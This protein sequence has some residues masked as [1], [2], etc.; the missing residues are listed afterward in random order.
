MNT[1]LSR[2][3]LVFIIFISSSF[4]QQDCP[5]KINLQPMYGKEKKCPGQIEAD[6]I[7][8][9]AMDQEFHG[10]R[11]EASRERAERAWQYFY[12]NIPDTCMMRFNQAWLLDS[13]NAEVYWGFANLLGKQKKFTESLLFFNRSLQIN[14]ENALVWESASLSYGNLFLETQDQNKLDSC[15][16]YLKNS[17]KLKPENPRVYAKLVGI[18]SEI[19]Q[20]DSARKYLVLADQI[21]KRALNS[22]L[23][24]LV[25]RK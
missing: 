5:E 20:K 2:Y 9:E 11:K 3:W 4:G 6:R 1:L 15:V 7:F 17:A 24:K 14:P 22:E 21:D 25:L 18:Y 23:R 13:T 16:I 12:A 19:S 10:D 8:L